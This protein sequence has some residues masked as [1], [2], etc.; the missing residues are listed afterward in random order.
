MRRAGSDR[1]T[2]DTI[3][4]SE[5]QRN[6]LEFGLGASAE[7]SMD[8]SF[9]PSSNGSPLRS[10]IRDG[11]GGWSRTASHH[12]GHNDVARQR[13]FVPHWVS[14]KWNSVWQ[15]A[16][17]ESIS[18]EDGM[19]SPHELIESDSL[20]RR[21]FPCES[22]IDRHAGDA[23]PSGSAPAVYGSPAPLMSSD[24]DADPG[25]NFS[26]RRA[27]APR[28]KAWGVV[29]SA[30]FLKLLPARLR[31]ADAAVTPDTEAGHVDPQ[32]RHLR[33]QNTLQVLKSKL[34]TDSAERLGSRAV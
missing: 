17:Q 3:D 34:Q 30:V 12:G 33:R 18:E 31:S 10:A 21:Y 7:E 24:A 20:F 8:G 19:L 4:D 9:A 1:T 28:S 14:S 32:L 16:A 23:R 13:S 5:A 2:T 22:D 6:D 11:T 29:R 26:S 25:T 27:S 15:P